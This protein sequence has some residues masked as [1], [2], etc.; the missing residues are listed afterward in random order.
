MTAYP[1]SP[2]ALA[3][4]KIARSVD[5][6]PLPRQPG[7]QLEFFVERLIEAEREYVEEMP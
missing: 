5:E 1:S 7:G 2:S 4:K 3:L 6:W